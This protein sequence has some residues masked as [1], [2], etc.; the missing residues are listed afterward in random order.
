MQNPAPQLIIMIS[1][2]IALI[3][4]IVMISV[5]FIHDLNGGSATAAGATGFAVFSIGAVL[6]A[7]AYMATLPWRNAY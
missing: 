7:L 5:Q 2:A 3:T 6:E 4:G 1:G